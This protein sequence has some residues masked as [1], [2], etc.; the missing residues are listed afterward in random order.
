MRPP[1][2]RIIYNRSSSSRGF[3]SS[4]AKRFVVGE[5]L[6]LFFLASSDSKRRV[7][8]EN[9]V[10]VKT[11]DANVGNEERLNGTAEILTGHVSGV[12]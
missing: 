7:D 8:D 9:L 5:F 3:A 2:V 6:Q 10:D 11:F 12:L 1:K 4:F